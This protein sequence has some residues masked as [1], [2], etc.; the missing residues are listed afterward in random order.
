[1]PTG[2]V[3]LVEGLDLLKLM[4]LAAVGSHQAFSSLTKEL[5]MSGGG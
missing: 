1:M 3:I 4:L 5:R 2:F